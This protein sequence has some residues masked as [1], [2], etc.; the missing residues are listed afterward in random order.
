MFI[1]GK[2]RSYLPESKLCLCFAT[3]FLQRIL[4]QVACHSLEF[5]ITYTGIGAGAPWQEVRVSGLVRERRDVS[6]FLLASFFAF[7][8]LL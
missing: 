3:E 1:R 2:S 7:E 5:L 6:A 8:N 4:D